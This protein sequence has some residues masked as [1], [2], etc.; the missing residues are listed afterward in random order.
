MPDANDIALLREY[1]GRNSESAFADLVH[2]HINLVYSV[3]LRFTGNCEDAQDATQAVFIILAR[4]AAT[5][6]QRTILTGWLY[7]TTR[8]TPQHQP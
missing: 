2:R 5:L 7:E 4:K 6:N 8:F 3:A 1:A